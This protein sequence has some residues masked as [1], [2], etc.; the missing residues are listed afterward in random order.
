MKIKSQKVWSVASSHCFLAHSLATAYP[1]YNWGFET[2]VFCGVGLLTLCPQPT[3]SRLYWSLFRGKRFV[4]LYCWGT[5]SF[6]DPGGSY[7]IAESPA[8]SRHS[9]LPAWSYMG[10]DRLLI[11]FTNFKS[12]WS[13]C[14]KNI[15]NGIQKHL[16]SKFQVCNTGHKILHVITNIL[17][18]F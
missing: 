9:I 13:L 11:T 14:V 7:T 18:L 2:T 6:D 12:H 10:L 17:R 3:G 16:K 1:A 4:W 5:S 15:T 8:S